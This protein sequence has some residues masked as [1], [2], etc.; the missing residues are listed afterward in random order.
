M[1]GGLEGAALVRKFV[2]RILE[3][4]LRTIRRAYIPKCPEP[5]HYDQISELEYP[6]MLR[7]KRS[8]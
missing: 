5:L 4:G 1:G 6:S 2:C 3:E 8:A 7:L